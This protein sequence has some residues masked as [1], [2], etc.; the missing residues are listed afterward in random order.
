MFISVLYQVFMLK[1]VISGIHIYIR[2]I[3]GIYANIRPL[4]GIHA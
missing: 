3:P 2:H 4:S 1:S